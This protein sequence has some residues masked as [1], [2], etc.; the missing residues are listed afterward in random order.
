MLRTARRDLGRR[1]MIYTLVSV[2]LTKFRAFFGARVD[3][4]QQRWNLRHGYP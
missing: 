1:G 3:I 4:S 2:A